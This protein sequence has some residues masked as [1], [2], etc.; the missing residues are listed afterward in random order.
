LVATALNPFPN[1]VTIS[2]LD[3]NFPQGDKEIMKILQKMN[4][5]LRIEN[6]VQRIVIKGVRF[7]NFF[8]AK[9]F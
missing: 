2:N 1:I 9:N 5:N 8:N 4:A 6:W 3:Y 7:L